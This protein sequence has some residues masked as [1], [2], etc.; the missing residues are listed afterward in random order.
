MHRPQLLELQ[1]LCQHNY[2]RLVACFVTPGQ[3]A[4]TT[5]FSW[6]MRRLSKYT[7][8]LDIQWM[9]QPPV[10]NRPMDVRIHL[11]HDVRMAEVVQ[12]QGMPRS[13]RMRQ[14]YPN[15][16]GWSADEKLQSNRFLGELLACMESSPPEDLF[17]DP[18]M[19]AIGLRA[20]LG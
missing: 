5:D 4:G 17:Q 19:A 8:Q 13:I 10:I 18:S 9:L 16:Y 2:H 14:H 3:P 6:T 11:Y 1:D 15:P 7:W 12:I 20:S